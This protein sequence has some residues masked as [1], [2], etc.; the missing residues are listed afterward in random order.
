MG[1][2]QVRGGKDFGELAKQFSEC[3]SR[4]RGG[5]LG[6]FGK[7]QMVKPFERA[8]FALQ[9]GQLSEPVQTEFGWHIIK[10]LDTKG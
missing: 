4:E 7:G 8:A 5:A 10:C 6:W 9:K 3:P 2:G 1:L